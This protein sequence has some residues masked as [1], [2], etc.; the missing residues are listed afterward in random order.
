MPHF[1]SAHR[2]TLREIVFM[3]YSQERKNEVIGILH[4]QAGGDFAECARLTGVSART[5]EKWN[6]E[7]VPEIF[8]SSST[9]N[10][11]EG[12]LP[13]PAAIK[14]RIIRR[15]SQIVETCTDPKKLMDT[16]E[17]ISKFERESGKNRET[18]F[19]M[20]ER[21]MRGE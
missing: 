21:E 2:V 20:I 9:D 4:A 6:E 13:T 16:Y 10:D 11:D 15:V 17:A 12:E 3:V 7:D 14:D 18:L 5:I 8:H 1:T 19:E